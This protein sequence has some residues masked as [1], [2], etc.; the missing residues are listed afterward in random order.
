MGSS[1]DQRPQTPGEVARE[2]E[3]AAERIGCRLYR[4]PADMAGP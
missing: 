4:P 2:I 3:K 1:V